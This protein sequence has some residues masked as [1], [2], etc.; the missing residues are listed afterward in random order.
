MSVQKKT[1]FF[2]LTTVFLKNEIAIAREAIIHT[3]TKLTGF[4]SLWRTSL[5][6]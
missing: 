6:Q 5:C 1:F 4:L 3:Q 2:V